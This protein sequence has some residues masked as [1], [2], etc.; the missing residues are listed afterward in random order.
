VPAV[1]KDLLL[2]A[3]K[4]A[5]RAADDS[6]VDVRL[7]GSLA[8]IHAVY[9]LFNRIWRPDKNNP[10]VTVDQL[11]AMTYAGNYL[12][13]AFDRGSMVGACVG[14]FAA[15]PGVSMHSHVAGVAADARGR[16][17]GFALKLHQ[18]AWALEQGLTEV[19]W[20]FDPL[21]R[22]NAYFNLVKLGA[23][24]RDY[25]VDFYGDMD[26]GINIGQ[27]SD[28][29]L[30]GWDLT[31]DAVVDACAGRAVGADDIARSAAP[32]AL[33]EDESGEPEMLDEPGTPDASLVRVGIPAN[34]ENLR[35]VDPAAGRRWRLAVRDVLGGLVAAEARVTGFSRSGWYEVKR[36]PR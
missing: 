19:T 30:V 11:R 31:S 36:A 9:S 3:V 33:R 14:F 2:S 7:I 10:P 13:G 27:G 26:D 16:S 23:V 4:V 15:P 29:L 6:G 18:R 28:R 25:L 32:F 5:Q 12:A 34:V 24:A 21:V 1:R 20:T 22:R 17:V 35:Q 8:E